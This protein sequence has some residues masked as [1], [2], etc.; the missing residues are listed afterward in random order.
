MVIWVQV[1]IGGA[2]YE[3]PSDSLQSLPVKSPA[4]FP[5]L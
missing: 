3:T 2:A 4:S 5:S 1:W